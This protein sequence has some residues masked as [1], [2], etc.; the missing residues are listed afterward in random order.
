MKVNVL[1]TKSGLTVTPGDLPNPGIKPRSPALQAHALPSESLRNFGYMYVC[2]YIYI[3]MY[4]IK[5]Y[6]DVSSVR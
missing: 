4:S 5:T 2:I 1:V 3:Y 6:Q